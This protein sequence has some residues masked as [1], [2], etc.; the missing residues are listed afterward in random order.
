[1][2]VG[3]THVQAAPCQHPL[4]FE[5]VMQTPLQGPGTLAQELIRNSERERR[6]HDQSG[7][8]R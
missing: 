4:K 1:M 6:G 5:K 3:A 8:D 7:L 2:E